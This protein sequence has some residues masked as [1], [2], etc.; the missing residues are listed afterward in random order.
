MSLGNWSLGP[1]VAKRL[2]GDSGTRC[3][4]RPAPTEAYMHDPEWDSVTRLLAVQ[5]G[6]NRP[7]MIAGVFN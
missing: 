7:L 3:C 5:G 4:L 2:H 1:P 6:K